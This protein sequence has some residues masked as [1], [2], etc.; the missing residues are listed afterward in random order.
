MKWLFMLVGVIFPVFRMQAITSIVA[1][2]AVVDENEANIVHQG[3]LIFPLTNRYTFTNDY[4]VYADGSG[5]HWGVDLHTEVFNPVFSVSMGVVVET[6]DG[7]RNNPIP[8]DYTSPPYVSDGTRGNYVTIQTKI[9]DEMRYFRYMHL[10]PGTLL[11]KSGDVVEAGAKIAEVGN[12]GLSWGSHLH[13][14]LRKGLGASNK[15]TL[16]PKTVMYFG[17]RGKSYE[18]DELKAS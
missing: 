17:E 16:D 18:P 7:A 1:S 2:T 6:N 5:S 10:S 14:E 3:D 11:V 12:S 4:G 8:S 13:L 15:D 9:N